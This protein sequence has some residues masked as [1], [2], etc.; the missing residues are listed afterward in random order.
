MRL[1][2]TT[3][4]YERFLFLTILALSAAG[5]FA[6]AQTVFEVNITGHNPDFS[7]GDGICQT[8]PFVDSCSL[9]AAIME[10]NVHP[11]SVGP[12]IIRFTNMPLTDGLAVIEIF[13]TDLPDITQPLVIDG[14][15][16]AGE[17]VID[18]Y[19]EVPYDQRTT[20]ITLATG[21]QGS[22]IRGL[23]ITRFDLY[24]ILVES[25]LNTIVENHI[26]LLQ[27]GSDYGNGDAAIYVT[28]HANQIGKAVQGNVLGHSGGWGIF[29][30]GGTGNLIRGNYVGTNAAGMDLGNLQGISIYGAGNTVGGPKSQ[31]NIVGHNIIG[32]ILAGSDNTIQGNYIGTNEA[33][34][35][36]GNLQTGILIFSPAANNKIGYGKN[37]TIPLTT[38]K[39]NTIAYNGWGGIVFPGN[40]IQNSIRGNVFFENSNDLT[41]DRLGIDLGVFNGITP[42]D[43]DDADT[44]ANNLMNYPD[45]A[46]AFYRPG[47]DAL[48]IEY[49][50]SSDSSIV[51][52][53]LTIDAYLV[54]H[55]NDRQAK[56][57]IGTNIYTAP[58]SVASFEI[59]ANSLTWDSTQYVVL[60]AT[61]S[62][63]N[64]SE[65]SAP[66]GHLGTGPGSLLEVA[67][68]NEADMMFRAPT[69]AAKG[70]LTAYPN[71][72][73]PRTSIALNP[74]V[75][76]RVRVTIHDAL[77][78][79]VALVDDRDVSAGTT[80]TFS[81]DGTG[82][83][84]GVYLLHA[85]GKGFV[86]TR[87]LT[88]VK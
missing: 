25:H 69:D 18:G 14:T 35:D 78:R 7:P 5:Q 27:D 85:Q 39:A 67:G 38:P 4:I 10:A 22:T 28:G 77:G 16:S 54:D 52:Y 33:G 64:T 41:T 48:I 80:H 13:G 46:R 29:I 24:G 17:I 50:V 87:R 86:A 47:S 20:G 63:G 65:F 40:S 42:N 32:I 15:T 43:A 37:A 72:F 75:S 30:D 61:D 23:S 88:I 62:L 79:Q 21:S 51:P 59:D 3:C 58:N 44:G 82:L 31:G 71:P 49:S 57:F 83:A 34:D 76:G 55:A 2:P 68:A 8:L 6:A 56:T 36:L 19:T 1:H 45:V 66:A 74:P 81:F 12:D 9:R 70:T 11:N 26:G 53:P 60:T 84:S 73:N